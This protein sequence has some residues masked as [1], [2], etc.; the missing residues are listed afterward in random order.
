MSA[1]TLPTAAWNGYMAGISKKLRD[2]F[3]HL[4][5]QSQDRESRARCVRYAREQHHEFLEYLKAA[6]T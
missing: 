2:R 3:I 5:R 1:A 6:R 4:A